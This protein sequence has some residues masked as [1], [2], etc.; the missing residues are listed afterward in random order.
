MLLIITIEK[1]RLY[2]IKLNFIKFY[3]FEILYDCQTL[4][5]VILI[6][7]AAAAEKRDRSETSGK[8]QDVF[9]NRHRR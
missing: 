8:Q 9:E 4:R 2:L 6:I 1:L 3:Y 5:R 7:S